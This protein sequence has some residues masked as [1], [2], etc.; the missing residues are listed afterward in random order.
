MTETARAAAITAVWDPGKELKPMWLNLPDSDGLC[1]ECP[2][3]SPLFDVKHGAAPEGPGNIALTC[4]K[5]EMRDGAIH[6]QL[7]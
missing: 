3:Y 4:Y 1:I 7:S 6:I 5:S 2:A